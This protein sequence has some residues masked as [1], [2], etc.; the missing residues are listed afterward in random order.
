MVILVG[1]L[2]RKVDFM[3]LYIGDLLYAVMIYFGIQFLNPQSKSINSA[4][5]ALLFCYCIE[6]LQLCD[7]EWMIAMRNTFFGRYVLGLGFLW[8][9]IIAYTFGIVIAYYFEK[10]IMKKFVSRN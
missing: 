9:D 7:A 1:L 3:P 10:I 6:L 2:S 8:S 5:V 4:I